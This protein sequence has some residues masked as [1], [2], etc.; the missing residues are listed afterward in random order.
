MPRMAQRTVRLN[1]L[2]QRE[3]SAALHAE[4]R[5][6]AVRITVTGVDISPDLRNAIVFYSVV[7]SEDDRAEARALLNRVKNRLRQIVSR[8]VTL[9]YHPE[10][11]FS[12]DDSSARGSHLVDLLDRVAE[13][14][15]RRDDHAKP[16][17]GE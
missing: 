1:E 2:L 8:R 6:E 14:D 11:R 17:S 4:W 15:R 5:G 9:K 3:I 13:E 16:A 12:Y 7:G 10:Y